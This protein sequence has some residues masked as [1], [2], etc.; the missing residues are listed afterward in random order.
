MHEEGKVVGFVPTMGALHDGHLALC[1]AAAEQCDEVVVS[2]FVNPLQFGPNEDLA[3]YPRDLVGDIKKLQTIPKVTT[4]FSPPVGE[5]YRNGSVCEVTIGKLNDQLKEGRDRPGHFDGVATVVSKLFNIVEPQKA[6][7]GQKDGAQCV[8]LK[9]V[10]AD[11]C[12]NTEMCIVQTVREP[13][14]LA[15]SSRNQYLSASDR[16]NAITLYKAITAVK[17]AYNIKGERDASTLFDMGS[18]IL[19]SNK[20]VNVQYLDICNLETAREVLRGDVM[21]EGQFMVSVAAKVGQTRLI[22]NRL[23]GGE[24][25]N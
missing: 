12:Y 10:I 11:L 19:E 14:G 23:M 1:S 8:V 16:A 2:I 24:S 22:D 25:W 21:G 6:F 15:M 18:A 3:T 7:F 13:D 5:I 20:E 9:Q 17:E 4:V